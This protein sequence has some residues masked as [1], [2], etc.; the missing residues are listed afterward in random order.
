MVK[1][2]GLMKVGKCRICN[3]QNSFASSI[4]AKKL[5]QQSSGAAGIVSESLSYNSMVRTL[6]QRPEEIIFSLK[7]KLFKMEKSS[8]PAA[9][10]KK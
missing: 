4:S 1:K 6:C 10:G 5:A 8:C 9:S 3:L 2:R 7:T